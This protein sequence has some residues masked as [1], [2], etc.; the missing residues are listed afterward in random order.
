MEAMRVLSLQTLIYDRWCIRKADLSLRV[1]D[2]E[3]WPQSQQTPSCGSPE[4]AHSRSERTVDLKSFGWNGLV[5]KASAPPSFARRR[6]SSSAC[7]VRTT[8]GI[9][10]V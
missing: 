10:F 8:T 6:D 1:K 5:T 7:A 4:P 3:V 9:V 2:L